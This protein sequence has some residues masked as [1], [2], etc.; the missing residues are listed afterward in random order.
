MTSLWEGLP[1]SLLEA[2]YLNKVCIVSNVEG[3]KDVVKSDVN[4]Y[5]CNNLNDFIKYIK[6]IVNN[7]KLYN[8][9]IE[10]SK[11]NIDENFNV[12]NMINEYKN[13]YY[14]KRM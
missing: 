14:N 10:N 2:M 6:I 11:K 3:N 9:L 8:N 5:V 4:G 1:I 12:K 13:L 7:R